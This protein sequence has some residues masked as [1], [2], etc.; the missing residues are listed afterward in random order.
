MISRFKTFFN[1]FLTTK[2]WF[3]ISLAWFLPQK[4]VLAVFRNGYKMKVSKNNF[5]DFRSC[6]YFFRAFPS[7]KIDNSM[8]KINHNQFDLFFD[9]NKNWFLLGNLIEIFG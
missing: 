1:I 3:N 9:I 4:E 2:N 6:V 7:G 5:S 8:V